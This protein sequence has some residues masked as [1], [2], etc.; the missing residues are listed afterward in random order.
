MGMPNLPVR[1]EH[2]RLWEK[3]ITNVMRKLG[4]IEGTPEAPEHIYF[5]TVR[6]ETVGGGFNTIEPVRKGGFMVPMVSLMD[7]VS[8]GQKLASIINLYGDEVDAIYSPF[9]DGIILSIGCNIV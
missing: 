6:D 1:E 2:V 8:K 4:M 5:E 3:T 7:R 9:N